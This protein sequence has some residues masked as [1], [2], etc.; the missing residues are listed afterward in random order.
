VFG[1]AQKFDR[2]P[3]DPTHAPT[4]PQQLQE[5]AV[6]LF[7]SIDALVDLQFAITR[8]QREKEKETDAQ[9]TE[10]RRQEGKASFSHRFIHPSSPSLQF[11][12][13]LPLL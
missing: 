4:N 2:I 11:V 6:L 1:T 9:E 13:S 10:R 5:T 3:L 8:R 12:G 7:N